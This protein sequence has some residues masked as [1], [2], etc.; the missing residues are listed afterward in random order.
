MCDAQ[1]GGQLKIISNSSHGNSKML[2]PTS[3]YPLHPILCPRH[4]PWRLWQQSIL[5]R[6]HESDVD[7]IEDYH[8]GEQNEYDLENLDNGRMSSCFIVASPRGCNTMAWRGARYS[9]K[10]ACLFSKFD[11]LLDKPPYV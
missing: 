6:C 2:A 7:C 4:S 11:S 3:F 1:E 8:D 9:P 10:I 5:L